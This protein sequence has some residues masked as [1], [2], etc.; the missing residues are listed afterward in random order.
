M[1]RKFK[2]VQYLLVEDWGPFHDLL[3]DRRTTL[4]SAAAWLKSRG[5]SISRKAVCNYR[6]A[7][8]NLAIEAALNEGETRRES[9]RQVM[10]YS[11]QMNAR[12]LSLLALFAAFLASP[13]Q[14]KDDRFTSRFRLAMEKKSRG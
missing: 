3:R 14:R 10:F 2:I 5:Y 8:E 7:V 4:D 1:A 12:Q 13:Y 11:E 9:L 6:R